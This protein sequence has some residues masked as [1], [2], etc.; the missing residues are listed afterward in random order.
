MRHA[1]KDEEE[2]EETCGTRERS[3]ARLLRRVWIRCESGHRTA[4]QRRTASRAGSARIAALGAGR[5]DE[6]E[7]GVREEQTTRPTCGPHHGQ[8]I[9][10]GIGREEEKSPGKNEEG[11][12]KTTPVRIGGVDGKHHSNHRFPAERSAKTQAEG[13]AG[14]N[15]PRCTTTAPAKALH[16]VPGRI[17]RQQ[18]SHPS[19]H[20]RSNTSLSRRIRSNPARGKV[21][22]RVAWKSSA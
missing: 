9:G 20:G 11:A 13:T 21:G 1:K 3:T 6:P 16:H 4:S 12:R 2:T 7:M 22:T 5:R 8:W 19:A 17:E 18:L 14:Q 10:H 15:Q